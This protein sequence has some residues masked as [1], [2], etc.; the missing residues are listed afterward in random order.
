MCTTTRYIH[1]VERLSM[2]KFH[3]AIH[4][5]FLMMLN[6]NS[7]AKLMS[8]LPKNVINVYNHFFVH[9]IISTT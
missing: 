3:A 9:N 6:G 1:E 7:S 5:F 8:S 2:M 4:N